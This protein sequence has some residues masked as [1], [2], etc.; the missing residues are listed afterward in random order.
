MCKPYENDKKKFLSD[1]EESSQ[2]PCTSE[3]ETFNSYLWKFIVIRQTMSPKLSF[4]ILL[5]PSLVCALTNFL[6]EF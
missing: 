5:N 3:G 4:T 1:W 2:S 6:L